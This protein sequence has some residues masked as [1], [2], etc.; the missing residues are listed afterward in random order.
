MGTSRNKNKSIKKDLMSVYII[1][2][3]LLFGAIC[4][5]LF[6]SWL[7]TADRV[8]AYIAED[9]NDTIYKEFETFINYSKH[10]NELTKAQIKSDIINLND[11]SQ[12]DKFFA[13]LL[14]VHTGAPIYSISFGTE[15]GE[16]YGARRNK[17][18]DP[19]IMRNNAVT[20]GK[21][22]YYKI[23]DDMSAGDMV[24][25]TDLFDPRTRPWYKAAKLNRETSISPLYKHF[26]M[27]DLAIS[28]GTPIYGRDGALWGV[29]G[30][31][32]TLSRI[33]SFISKV[34]E[35]YKAA[36][37]IVDRRTGELVANSF[38]EQN[39]TV[40]RDGIA[41][42]RTIRDLKNIE[43]QKAF[44]EL[45]SY[46]HALSGVVKRDT[47]HAHI[48]EFRTQGADMLFITIIPD[49]YLTKDIHKRMK[50]TLL[51]SLVIIFAASLYYLRYVAGLLIP[52]ESL[53]RSADRFSLGDLSARAAIFRND[54]VGML[55]HTFN[56]L[57]AA[58]SGHLGELESKVNERTADLKYAN[59]VLEEK[60]EDLKLILDSTAEGIFG[61]D[62]DGKCTFFNESGL[63][64]LGYESQDELLGKDIHST[65]H[66][67]KPD[68]AP[69]P[70]EGCR[71]MQ[72]FRTGERFYVDDEI[73]WRKEGT[74]FFV[75]YSTYPQYRDGKL[76]GAVVTFMDDT[77]QRKN[78]EHIRFLTYHD[79]LTGI[80]NRLYFAEETGRLADERNFPI[81]V[82]FGDLN[83][84]KLTNDVFGHTAGDDLLKNAARA[85][86]KF[87]GD[88]GIAARM[89]GDEFALFMPQCDEEEAIQLMNGIKTTFLGELSEDMIGSIALGAS[90]GN[91]P[92][93]PLAA[94][95]EEA[96][97]SM[98]KEKTI[99]RINN[100]RAMI[101]KIIDRLHERSPREKKHSQNVAALSG[102]IA[103]QIGLSYSDINRIS[104]NGYFHD[105]GKIVLEDNIL[106]KSRR[107]TEEEYRKMQQHPTVG[108]RILN[109]FDETMELAE[110]VLSHHEHWDGSGYPKGTA[111]KDIP[112]SSRIIAVAEA[113]DAMTND[114]YEKTRTQEEA[115]QEIL[116][117][118]GTRF[119][120]AI[121]DAFIQVI[122]KEL[123]DIRR[124]ITDQV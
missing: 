7:R 61:L 114:H 115:V 63:R 17:D 78:K 109:L 55:A 122:S 74:S 70:T 82:I 71:I 100:N 75:R 66:H 33:D 48:A 67:S 83:G 9:M 62:R 97:N 117:F 13:G 57:A 96:E 116:R 30:S 31:H 12:R 112:L 2:T 42:R 32:M 53:S 35:P 34:V 81:S 24:L 1:S 65:I 26:V 64:M 6:C 11:E 110:G 118:S 50:L 76:V 85:F 22:R 123:P 77:E 94:I 102:K 87:S 73:F 80:Y 45:A 36:A 41:E 105:I 68:G 59:S 14:N 91:S 89:G 95:I 111:G 107:Y 44:D 101:R 56:V 43:F 113:Y 86:A 104:E 69:F 106:S 79:P 121:V 25:E 58:I 99:N 8:L 19:E 72:T 84:L 10:I 98:Y 54:E 120:P 5:V 21:T 3:V 28:V 39:F 18:D 88:R 16:Y 15:R 37:V 49:A 52:L 4:A 108:F 103:S 90:T 51:F 20:G 46:G 29:L 47:S 60:R 40:G 38:G 23:N 93:R 124:N 119:D 92:E 27:N